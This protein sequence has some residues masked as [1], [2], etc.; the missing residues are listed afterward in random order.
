MKQLVL[1]IFIS[2]MALTSSA[3]L[4][5]FCEAKQGDT[6]HYKSGDNYYI[7]KGAY[8]YK[9][10]QDQIRLIF[11]KY[12][13]RAV[14]EY[15]GKLYILTP[16][17][18]FVRNLNDY[19]FNTSFATTDQTIVKS[20]QQAQDMTI[21]D[22]F[23]YIAHGSLGLI[24]ISIASQAIET[25]HE[26]TL[27]HEKGQIS[28]ATGI[29]Y[30]QGK[31]FVMLDNVTYNFSTRKRAFEG[32]VMLDQNLNQIREIPIRQNREALHMPKAIVAN[33]FLISKNI[34]N[35]YFYKISEFDRVKT[36]WPKRRLFDFD[37][38]DLDSTPAIENGKVY[39]CFNQY[40]GKSFKYMHKEFQL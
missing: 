17:H 9:F 32:L 35:L 6:G 16:N 37:G 11:S 23:I 3:N 10:E 28:T 21:A 4:D 30:S 25:T 20:H 15:K 13:V 29:D 40:D 34:Q 12:E 14:K 33:G 27:P 36:L 18:I 24:K 19:S 38:V 39:G 2:L 7:Y 1:F 5:E 26:F 31:L 8:L 22:E